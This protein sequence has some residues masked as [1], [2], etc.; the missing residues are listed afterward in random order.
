MRSKKRYFFNYLLFFLTFLLT[1]FFGILFYLSFYQIIDEK[2]SL[3]KFLFAHPVYLL[4]GLPYSLSLIGILLFHEMGHYFACRSHNISATLPYFIP[5]PNL[6]GTFGAVIRIQEP[7]YS[8]RA[9]FDIGVTGPIAGFAVA[10]PVTILGIALS[11][12][13][14]FQPNTTL[15]LGDPLLFR[16]LFSVFFKDMAAGQTIL[17]HPIG[18]AGWFGMLATALNLMPT[19]QLDGGHIVYALFGQKAKVISKITVLVLVAF[20]ILFWKG[21]LFWA[22]LITIIGTDH[23]P[24]FSFEPL[25]RKRKALALLTLLILILSFIPAPL[26]IN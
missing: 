9:L 14:S 12:Q 18:F 7:I 1:S 22:L 13:V 21:W 3:W 15:Q 23:P 26:V 25:D 2:S 24:L 6:F 20:G 10:L 8:R 4:S 11:R 5:F 17:I 19:G 16:F